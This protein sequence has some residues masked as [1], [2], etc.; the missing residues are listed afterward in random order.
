VTI[1]PSVQSCRWSEQTLFLPWP[2]WLEAWEFPWCCRREAP[3]PPRLLP[4]VSLCRACREW[5]P[6][7]P[8]AETS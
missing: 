4:D 3:D 6:R 1:Q 5:A 8:D 2:M 7:S